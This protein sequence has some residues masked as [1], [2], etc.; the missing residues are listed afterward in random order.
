MTPPQP[1]GIR[2]R[3]RPPNAPRAWKARGAWQSEAPLGDHRASPSPR[4]SPPFTL[5]VHRHERAAGPSPCG[6]FKPYIPSNLKV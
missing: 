4:L 6:E 3:A 1:S 2:R 5:E